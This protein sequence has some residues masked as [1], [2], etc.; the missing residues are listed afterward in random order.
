MSDGI[1]DGTPE[2]QAKR[3]K[4]QHEKYCAGFYGGGPLYGRYFLSRVHEGKVQVQTWGGPWVDVPEGQK[5][6]D[7]N[8]RPLRKDWI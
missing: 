2:Q 6:R 1:L 3:L 8:G 7:H 5:W 4:D